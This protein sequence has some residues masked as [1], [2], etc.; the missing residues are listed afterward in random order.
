MSMVNVGREL[1]DAGEEE[2]AVS[3]PPSKPVQRKARVRRRT[4]I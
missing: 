4:R 1:V 2:H 3:A